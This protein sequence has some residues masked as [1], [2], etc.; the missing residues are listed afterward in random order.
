VERAKVVGSVNIL[1]LRKATEESIRA[2]ESFGSV[3]LAV[4]SAETA[5][6]LRQLNIGSLN[7][8]IEVP[9]DTK[10]ELVMG[11]LSIGPEHFAN[12]THPIGF[13]VMGPFTVAP[14]VRAEDLE[15]G[16]AAAM[17]MG[18]VSVPDPLAGILQAKLALVMGPVTSYPVFEK[19]HVGPFAVD[20]A[21]LEALEPGTE[22]S[23]VGQLTFREPIPVGLIRKKLAKVH[24]T[25][26]TV[27]FAQNEQEVRSSLAGAS[28]KVRVIPDG[29]RVIEKEIDLTRELLASITDRKLYFTK[30]V[31]IDRVIDPSLFLEKIEG[32]RCAGLITCPVEL[33]AALANVC[34]LLDA[35]T[36][37]YEGDLWEIE[38]TSELH[39]ARFDHLEGK[40]TL[41]V[42][43]SLSVHPE[44]TPDLLKSRLAAVHLYGII[45]CSPEQQ[46]AIESRMDS[47]YGCFR[48]Y[49][50][51]EEGRSD[52]ADIGH[53][54][55]LAL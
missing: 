12:A 50:E 45:E 30:S 8:A 1:D 37:F 51:D 23:V 39:P 16:L 31:K 44:V 7:A 47:F 41:V 27:C 38:G 28:M 17:V 46:A 54:N 42:S 9:A 34:D 53:A 19:T 5:P 52:G 49:G 43:G 48:R 11:P 33:Q 14:D 6:L 10:V 29:Y 25:G 40:L 32:L 36:L 4:Y 35:E 26:M 20:V 15:R 24:A 2:Y 3:N 21:Y 18:P 13:L 55:Y 22:L